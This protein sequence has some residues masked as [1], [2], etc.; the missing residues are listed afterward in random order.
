MSKPSNIHG[1]PSSVTVP[2][3]QSNNLMCSDDNL[4]SR[5]LSN[6]SMEAY[7]GG[8]QV[9]VPFTWESQPGTPKVK[10]KEA[11]LPPLSPPPSY[12]SSPNR[13]ISKLQKTS[14]KPN[15]LKSI[16]FP[17]RNN[18]K[19]GNVPSLPCSPSSSSSSSSSSYS[20]RKKSYSVPSSPMVYPRKYKE[21]EDLY[22]IPAS[23][24][25]FGN[26]GSR[27]CSSMVKKVLQLGDFL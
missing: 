9:S 11:S 15:L 17:K 7:H 21:E 24:L 23:S 10:F 4:I 3:R 25:C 8:E 2:R 6:I 18:T 27:G 22:D 26:A 5:Q 14:P 13:Q 12:Y 16:L 19:K 20:S 1:R